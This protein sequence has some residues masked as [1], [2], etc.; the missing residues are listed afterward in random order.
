MTTN[1]TFSLVANVV[2]TTVTPGKCIVPSSNDRFVV[3]TRENRDLYGFASAFVR[4]TGAANRGVIVQAFGEIPASV[5]G[6]GA[7][8]STYVRVA[9]DGSLERTNND[10]TTSDDI[11]GRCRADGSVSLFFGLY[12]P[13]LAMLGGLG[14][15]QITA[16][17]TAG[18][19]GTIYPTTCRLF[20]INVNNTKNAVAYVFLY[21][22]TAEIGRLAVAANSTEPFYFPG[23][24]D[25]QTNVTYGVSSSQS[26][27]T[28]DASATVTCSA[29]YVE[30]GAVIT[31][32]RLD[33]VSPNTGS[34]AG[35]TAV[36]LTGINLTGATGVTFGGTAATSVVV[37]SSTQI[38]C[39][40]PAKAA[41]AYDVVVLHP[42]GNTTLTN[43]YT[44]GST[45]NINT[46]EWK[47]LW[48]GDDYNTSTGNWPGTASAGT[49][50]TL[51]ATSN[52][53]ASN[54]T[55]YNG[56]KSV[57]T[58]ANIITLAASFGAIAS[59]S[60]GFT[61]IVVANAKTVS[62]NDATDYLNECLIQGSGEYFY[63]K[64][65]GTYGVKLYNGAFSTGPTNTFALAALKIFVFRW[66]PASGG[67]ISTR[68][69]NGS[70]QTQ[71]FAGP[72]TPTG[73]AMYAGYSL[74]AGYTTNTDYACIA[75]IDRPLNDTEVTNCVNYLGTFYSVTP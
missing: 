56:K 9:D 6:L 33:S 11:V 68:L 35:G 17:T 48:F 7:G 49:S 46:L 25:A 20:S 47:G 73:G 22:G 19:S 31:T 70:W 21:D 45:F 67:T 26:T 54:G 40:T 62:T 13:S 4:Q 10:I 15:M 63:M 32:P 27:Y 60:A 18:P 50:G 8:E 34:T 61:F 65:S 14:A 69:G 1:F 64:N 43:G 12:T 74:N 2:D 41:G 55:T 51:T 71:T 3:A 53:A 37:N 57:N 58:S 38:T 29:Q 72:L 39:Q 30:S 24:Y 23:G 66:D 5:A 42:D 44:F 36:T 28:A 59:A 52:V 16:A 75:C